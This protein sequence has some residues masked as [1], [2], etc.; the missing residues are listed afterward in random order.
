[1]SRRMRAVLWSVLLPVFAPVAYAQ[2][3]EQNDSAATA[4]TK[5]KSLPLITTRTLEFTTD[6]GTWISLDLSPDGRTILFVLLGDLHRFSDPLRS[7][8]NTIWSPSGE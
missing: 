1:M 8:T 2:T 7:L 4:A 3:A 5:S 6:E